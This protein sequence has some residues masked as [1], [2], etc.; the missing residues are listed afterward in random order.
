MSS[1]PS[2]ESYLSTQISAAKSI[3][4]NAYDGIVYVAHSLSESG[5]YEVLKPLLPSITAYSEIHKDIENATTLILVDGNFL[6]SRKL[7]FAGTG[8]VN[9]DHD[10]V[11]RFGIAARNGMKL[12]LKTGMKAPLILTLPHKKYPQA[13]LVS[14]LGAMHELYVPLNVREEEKKTK[15]LVE[16]VKALDA[17]FTVCRDIGDSDPQRMSPP[18]VAEYII[19]AFNGTNIS[20]RVISDI[21]EIERE[22][23]LMAAVNRAANNVKGHQ[24]RLIWLEYNP[25]NP[26]NETIM[27]VGK[28][29]TIDIGGADLKTDG[30]MYGMCRDKYGAAVVAGIFKALEILKPKHVKFCGY[31][32]MVRNSIGSNSYTCDEIIRS[33][34]GK[35]IAI[36]NTDA[37]GRITMLDPL[38]K[39]LELAKLEKK[40][41]LFTLATLTGHCILSYGYMA[42]AMDNGPAHANHT[43]ETIRSR[44][45]IF[46]QPVEVSRLHWED[47]DFHEA[48]SEAADIR[49]S[50]TLPSVRTLRG[51]QGPAAFLLKGSRLDEHGC[52]SK[53]PIAYTH[54]DMGACMGSHPKVSY[55]NP[56]LALAAT[57]VFANS[58]FRLL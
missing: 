33:R 18:Y 9:R 19:N 52:D 51:H 21:S 27:L 46:G 40:P 14:A 49:Q 32:C 53:T 56:L 17:A 3:T 12:A 5:K 7:I 48:E 44:G 47:F 36:C 20:T 34:S 24:A 29:V 31:M 15:A 58:S 10:D 11:R 54:I 30:N 2:I 35:R 38:T 4:D 43:A 45:D 57:L 8:P 37:E 16:L 6:P 23:P 26:C 28:G 1:S 55:P 50:N 42:A 25:E 13:E 41:R 22:F 39:M